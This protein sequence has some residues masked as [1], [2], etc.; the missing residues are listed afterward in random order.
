MLSTTCT[1]LVVRRIFP[2]KLALTSPTNMLPRGLKYN[3]RFK[4]L[5]PK[6]GLTVAENSHH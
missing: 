6:K 1:N 5:D 3:D 2:Y 4:Q